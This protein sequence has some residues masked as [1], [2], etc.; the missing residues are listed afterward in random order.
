M[1]ERKQTKSFGYTFKEILQ[2]AGH[3]YTNPCREAPF[4][5]SKKGSFLF[6]MN[7][8]EHFFQM[9]DGKFHFNIAIPSGASAEE[10]QQIIA[11]AW[12]AI[13]PVFLDEKAIVMQAKVFVPLIEKET[14]ARD[15]A[16]TKARLQHMV[17]DR[18]VTGREREFFKKLDT[19]EKTA[20]RE[21]RAR[22]YIAVV[23]F[24]IYKDVINKIDAE[25]YKRVIQRVETNLKGA[26]ITPGPTPES[27]YRV[28][29][30][31]SFRIGQD[32]NGKYLNI[33][34]IT[35]LKRQ[36]SFRKLPVTR[37][38]VAERELKQLRPC[39][40]EPALMRSDCMQQDVRK[41]CEPHLPNIMMMT[42][43]LL[44]N[45]NFIKLA[46]GN[47][48][49]INALQEINTVLSSRILIP[50]LKTFCI[51]NI[52]LQ[53]LE[54]LAF[55]KERKEAGFFSAEKSDSEGK[56]EKVME[57]D[58]N[59]ILY[60]FFDAFANFD[61]AQSEVLMQ[62]FEKLISHV[63]QVQHSHKYPKSV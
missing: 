6:I 37:A 57:L 45:P 60:Q 19:E 7:I 2:Q 16:G 53:L 42:T 18:Y 63:Y 17:S 38:F 47:K 23:T 24:Y 33:Y 43:A 51:S 35:R 12:D 5:T 59:S 41:A 21:E 31:T 8:A 4:L 28:S 3:E 49:F 20:L 56:E 29:D 44:T 61:P 39:K 14:N 32:S 30:F 26:G 22:N 9:A 50:E 34:Q 13:V 58:K 11:R 55:A 27:D 36:K 1:E 40:I 10:K 62:F 15:D 52:S 54:N 46:G 48:R 25:G